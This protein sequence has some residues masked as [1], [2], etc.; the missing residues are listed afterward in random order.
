MQGVRKKTAVRRFPS[1][2]LGVEEDRQMFKRI[3]A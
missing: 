3:D 1:K 2:A